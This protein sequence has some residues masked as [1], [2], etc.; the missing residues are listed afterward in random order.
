MLSLVRV[1][2]DPLAETELLLRI[3]NARTDAG[4]LKGAAQALEECISLSRENRRPAR[5][6]S[7]AQSLARCQSLG[8]QTRE[9]EALFRQ[10]AAS[11][12]LDLQWRGLLGLGQ[13]LEQQDRYDEALAHFSHAGSVLESLPAEM[14]GTRQFAELYLRTNIANVYMSEGDFAAA[15][16]LWMENLDAAE[17]ISQPD[18]FLEALISEGVCSIHSGRPGAA[19]SHLQRAVRLCRLLGDR[20]RLGVAKA[21]LAD[22]LC[23]AGLA[24]R[25]LEEASEAA[26]IAIAIGSSRAISFSHLVMARS[27]A[28]NGQI[29]SAE[30]Q[31]ETEI[32][33]SNP[34]VRVAALILRSELR[35][36]RGNLQGSAADAALAIADVEG[37]GALHLQQ[38]AWVSL[39]LASAADTAA[40]AVQNAEELANR[41]PGLPDTPW[42]L[43]WARGR[44]C[45]H[46]RDVQAAAV[47]YGSAV[48]L[49]QELRADLGAHGIVEACLDDA[50][51]QQIYL[52]AVQLARSV[53]QNALA[54]GILIEAAWPPLNDRSHLPPEQRS[55]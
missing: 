43:E 11:D 35:R 39:A 29:E 38:G 53:G 25:A 28:L 21:Q 27:L 17:Q 1:T 19:A 48:K 32:R 44:I 6:L 16:R 52:T 45:E 30:M 24:Q 34:K 12:D 22:V 2:G 36:R 33:A 9:A 55:S 42:Q 41:S 14:N 10:V 20:E 31:L 49:I 15:S 47:C 7:A 50:E 18:Q 54:D 3:G 5:A 4:D 8:G 37:T 13:I 26:Q 23:A 46:Q 51:K 40:Q